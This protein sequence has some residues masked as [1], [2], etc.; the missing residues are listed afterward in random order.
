MTGLDGTHA[1]AGRAGQ[2][3]R[4]ERAAVR[5]DRDVIPWGSRFPS[6]NPSPSYLPGVRAM[7][8]GLRL[9]AGAVVLAMGLSGITGCTGFGV[10]E[11]TW[12]PQQNS[13]AR[14]TVAST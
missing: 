14:E 9:R 11:R 8:N 5:P 1:L 3:R 2:A 6:R 4:R 12:A 7:G 10:S 13:P